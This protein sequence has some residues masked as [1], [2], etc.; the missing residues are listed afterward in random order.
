MHSGLH[1]YTHEFASDL[2]IEQLEAIFVK[3]MKIQTDFCGKPPTG[4]TSPAWR[5]HPG[6]VDLM[7]K[8]GLKYSMF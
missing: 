8:L 4:F 2:T 5:N 3:T 1:G 6:Q 7:S